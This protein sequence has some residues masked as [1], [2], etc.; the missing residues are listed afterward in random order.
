RTFSGSRR[1]EVPRLMER[2][3]AGGTAAHGATYAF[4]FERSYRPVV[5]DAAAADV[6]RR[7]VVAGVGRDA[8]VEAVP[9]MG[10]EDFSA[11][12]QRAPGC[13]FFVGARNESRGI[14]HPHH[15]ELFDLEERALDYGTRVFVA[16]AMEM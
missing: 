14:V 10:G 4:D 13:F 9:T 15:H 3:I 8:L 1:D 7:A 2:I 6:M 11:Y 12:Q 5:K 16:A